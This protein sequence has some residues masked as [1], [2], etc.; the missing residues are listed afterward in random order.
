MFAEIQSTI[1]LTGLL[2]SMVRHIQSEHLCVYV[3]FMHVFI[4]NAIHSIYMF[5]NTLSI[6]WWNTQLLLKSKEE[7]FLL[8]MELKY[9]TLSSTTL[10]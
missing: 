3:I 6:C 7:H 5:R 4:S 10:Q 1:H 8:K 9:T 2:S